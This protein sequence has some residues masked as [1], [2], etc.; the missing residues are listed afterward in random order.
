MLL[1][2]PTHRDIDHLA[3]RAIQSATA[4]IEQAAQLRGHR[5]RVNRTRF[6]RLLKDPTAVAVTMSLTDEVMRMRS[7]AQGAVALRR[8]AENSSVHGLGFIDAIGLRTIAIL[9]LISPQIAMQIV[10]RRVRIAA[11]GIIL[12]AEKQPLR[13]HLLRR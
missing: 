9:S 6:A 10:H 7:A 2:L 5:D 13:S 3:E 12:P 8:V 1:P 11:S 4:L